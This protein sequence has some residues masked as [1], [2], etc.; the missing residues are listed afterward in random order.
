MT[1][2]DEENV[3]EY[4]EENT[5]S[6][7]VGHALK[8]RPTTEAAD[9]DPLIPG[10]GPRRYFHL[11]ATRI[12]AVICV[13]VDHGSPQFGQW[14]VIFTQNWVL[15]LLFVVSGTSFAM[16]KQSLSGY[17]G[18]L[19]FYFC[20]GVLINFTAWNL[21]NLDWRHSMFAVV[22]QFWF[23]AGLI[24]Y[25]VM[26]YPLKLYL[27]KVHNAA[28]HRFGADDPDFI[29]ELP[30]AVAVNSEAAAEP[31]AEP[32]A[33]AES[34]TGAEAG[35]ARQ[36][37][38]EPLFKAL[39]ILA[40]AL[41]G[42]TALVLLVVKPVCQAFLAPA[43]FKM[44]ES[45]MPSLGATAQYWGMPS[46][47]SQAQQ[48]IG[49]FC[50]YTQCSLCSVCIILLFPKLYHR[51]SLVGWLV[52]VNIFMHRVL[53]HRNQ[54]ER[55]FHGFDLYLLSLAIAH[56][57]LRRRAEVATIV[58]RYWF[59]LLIICGLIWIPGTNA[60]LD[61]EA[62]RAALGRLRVQSLDTFF[63][64]AW[65]VAGEFMFDDRI[66][67]V[68]KLYF[69]N[70]WALAVFLLHKAIHICFSFPTNWAILLALIPACWLW[71]RRKTSSF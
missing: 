60:R 19:F 35:E 44:F 15:Q 7:D 6:K 9:R 20:L 27:Q 68:D 1:S 49:S 12:A 21:A 47:L 48:T 2:Y 39:A 69:L 18:R 22:F 36:D 17:I 11:D 67:T 63:I 25:S 23:V 70:W 24:I 4:N 8:P 30:T 58:V 26:L 56:L 41:A 29:F 52:L 61:N 3:A 10:S 59:V 55:P 32:A 46:N 71:T 53:F 40:L 57:G 28:I 42:V 54:D 13:A 38:Y 65:V 5:A 37:S 33:E 51:T 16:S 34:A 64:L 62:P 66:F 14:N 50:L 45:L 43:V 31:A